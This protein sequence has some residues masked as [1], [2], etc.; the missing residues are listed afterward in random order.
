MYYPDLTW[1]ITPRYDLIVLPTNKGK[2]EAFVLNPR[3]LWVKGGPGS[4]NWGHVG[5]PGNRGGS[6]PGT[7]SPSAK[8]R[9]SRH[10]FQRMKERRK[11]KS[12]EDALTGLE[13]K[14]LPEEK[15]YKEL[16]FRGKLDGFI[17]GEGPVVKTVLDKWYNNRRDKM[18]QQIK[19][20]LKR[21]FKGGPGSGNYGHR[22]VPGRRGGSLPALSS[23]PLPPSALSEEM[24]VPL[25]EGGALVDYEKA[26]IG[27]A[28]GPEFAE[29]EVRVVSGEEID[30]H[31]Q[32]IEKT[33]GAHIVGVLT[34]DG[35]LLVRDEL[36]IGTITHELVHAAGIDLTKGSPAFVEGL[37]QALTE[38][39]CP[40]AFKTYQQ[41]VSYVRDKLAP[42]TG[43]SVRELG[44]AVIK[45]DNAAKLIGERIFARHG[46]HF[47]DEADWGRWTP[48]KIAGD[49][50]RS[51][52]DVLSSG[53]SVYGDYLVGEVGVLGKAV[54]GMPRSVV[55]FRK[56]AE[57]HAEFIEVLGGVTR[58]SR[59]ELGEGE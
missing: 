13:G 43:M 38:E 56:N 15:W 10:A 8:V 49:F 25:Y 4:G 58:V 45:T 50:G 30:D 36:P 18:G 26:I 14:D 53:H 11:F 46:Q 22:G 28:L 37:T 51:F 41:E 35:E 2:A 59:A 31:L 19:A 55:M 7:G 27:E 1:T 9:L 39:I 5:V 24:G 23:Q 6:A 44:T 34:S 57:G 3:G 12:V 29:K 32:S 47:S 42:L 40:R 52:T 54:D 16:R 33:S 17:V 48:E 21:F 20:W